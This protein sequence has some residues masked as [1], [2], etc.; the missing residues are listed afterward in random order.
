MLFSGD[1]RQIL[2]VI[3][4]GS[5]AQIVH[6]C[7]KFSALHAGFRILRLTE[8]M[9]L[10]SLRND[11]NA[12]ETALQFPNYLLRLGEGRLESAEDCMVDTLCSTV[13]DG[14]ESN[15][16]DVSWLTSRAI[17]STKKLEAH[18]NE[19]QSRL[20]VSRE[21]EDIPECRFSV[22]RG[23]ERSSIPCRAS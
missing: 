21:L 3:P 19:R 22:G 1:F 6:A 13:F 18:R 16:S 20:K 9:R 10:S 11:P 23:P 7:V 2:P 12:T 15:N 5:R 17:L 14:I 4:G 8:N